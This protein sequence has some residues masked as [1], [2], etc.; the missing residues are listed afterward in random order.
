MFILS[1]RITDNPNLLVS[2]F[3]V[4]VLRFA[5]FFVCHFCLVT[6]ICQKRKKGSEFVFR[7]IRAFM[8]AC[9]TQVSVML[10]YR[11]DMC[12]VGQVGKPYKFRNVGNTRLSLLYISSENRYDSERNILT[13]L[14]P[15]NKQNSPN[16]Y[17]FIST[18]SQQNILCV[19]I[20]SE[21]V[22]QKQK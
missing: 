22:A 16:L 13:S 6:F 21:R 10:T 5:H 18:N 2:I 12:I 20:Q 1:N 3:V 19:C 9:A 7:I 17:V 11:Y 15:K 14:H 4:V 8:R